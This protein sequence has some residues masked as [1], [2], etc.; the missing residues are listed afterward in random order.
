MKEQHFVTYDPLEELCFA[1]K[2]RINTTIKQNTIILSSWQHNVPKIPPT[3]P[4]QDLTTK[5][6]LAPTT[7]EGPP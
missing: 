3:I 5:P 7:Y 6:L 4:N 1:T 2:S